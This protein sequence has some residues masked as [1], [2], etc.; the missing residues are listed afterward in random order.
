MST[1]LIR[2]AL[3]VTQ[4]DERRIFRGNV[5]IE[6]SE[7]TAVDGE[8]RGADVV[9]EGKGKIVMPG[10]INTHCHVAM[11][12]LRGLVDD[13][14]LSDFLEKTFKLDAQRTE[15]GIYN[16][17]LL[18][19]YEMLDSG[20]TS[21][22]D[23]YYAEDVI[24]RATGKAG[25]RSFLSWNTLDEDKT[26]QK[27][28]P[29]RNADAFISSHGSNELISPSIGVQGVYVAGDET[30]MAAKE[31]AEKHDTLIHGH[32]AETR[33]EIYNFAKGHDSERPVEHLSRI[34]FLDSKFIAAHGAWVTLREVRLMA[35]AGVKVSW[36]PVSNAKLGVG[37]IA[38]VPEYLQNG[39][40]LSI[41]SDSAASNNSQ[42]LWSSM[43]FGSI[44]VKNDRWDPSATKA[45]VILDMATRNAAASLGRNDI[46]TIA[47]GMKA[48]LIMLDTRS[49]RMFPSGK[50]NVVS[51][52]IYSADSGSVSGVIVNGRILKREG[53]LVNFNAGDFENVDF[54]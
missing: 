33:E 7:I 11:T 20:V 15:K 25:I 36:N 42:D 18:G 12:H 5:F 30:Y 48:D 46:G 23:L 13:V 17:A 50:E 21:F 44:S 43:K 35:A 49:P 40:T 4:D 8:E 32:L 24:A 38:P 19:M 45:Q 14:P 16:S 3:I 22:L 1:I 34:G 10:L 29:V 28:N 53:K 39:V 52:I 54:V 2:D 27:G 26:T 6:G 41:G 37:G 9:M 47:P 51:N 31:V